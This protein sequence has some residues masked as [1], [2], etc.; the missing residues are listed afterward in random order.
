M[1][2]HRT[3][4]RQR[5]GQLCNKKWSVKR[6]KLVLNDDDTYHSLAARIE[7][8]NHRRAIAPTRHKRWTRI[9]VIDT[10]KESCAKKFGRLKNEWIGPFYNDCVAFI[11]YWFIAMKTYT[12]YSLIWETLIS[13]LVQI[14]NCVFLH[15]K[16]IWRTDTNKKNHRKLPAIIYWFSLIGNT[17]HPSHQTRTSFFSSLLSDIIVQMFWRSKFGQFIWF[18]TI[19]FY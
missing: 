2:T 13:R 19:F 14:G 4:T 15:W 17:Y 9:D 5:Q 10:D 16:L 18:P 11:P 6:R 7:C 1:H 12:I 8:A 3:G